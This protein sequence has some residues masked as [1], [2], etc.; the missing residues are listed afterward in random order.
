ME[1]LVEF[2]VSLGGAAGSIVAHRRPGYSTQAG[3]RAMLSSDLTENQVEDAAAWLQSQNVPVIAE[4]IPDPTCDGDQNRGLLRL[5]T[6]GERTD[7]D[8]YFHAE[9]G[10]RTN[11]NTIYEL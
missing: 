4:T 9:C 5:D 8:L 10:I 7:D 6:L 3:W 2:Y 1:S 11:E